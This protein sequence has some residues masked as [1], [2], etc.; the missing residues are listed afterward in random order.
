[1]SARD[2]LRELWARIREGAAKRP[3]TRA[4]VS[5]DADGVHIVRLRRDG[6]KEPGPAIRWSDVAR[7]AAYKRNLF[8]Y[9]LMCVL[10]ARADGSAVEVTEEMDGWTEFLGAMPNRLP[11]CRPHT[12]WYFEVMLPPF[13]ARYQEIFVRGLG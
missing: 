3:A 2:H 1:M 13:E 8:T 5:F 6:R 10:L 12:K 7:A 9:D 11:G 4:A